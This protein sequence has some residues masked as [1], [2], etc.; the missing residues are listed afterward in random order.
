VTPG[1]IKALQSAGFTVDINGVISAKVQ[2]ITPDFIDR[3]RKHGFHNLTLEKLI[4]LK[5]LGVL[6]P[7]GEI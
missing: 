3:A 6:D 2:D 4:E 7:Q 5:H 1:Y